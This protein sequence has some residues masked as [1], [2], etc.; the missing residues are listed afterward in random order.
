MSRRAMA[1]QLRAEPDAAAAEVAQ[2]VADHEQ[3]RALAEMQDK[4]RNELLIAKYGSLKKA[5]A[6]EEQKMSKA[7]DKAKTAF[8][9]NPIGYLAQVS[10]CSRVQ[11]AFDLKLSPSTVKRYVEQPGNTPLEVIRRA[12]ILL[13]EMERGGRRTNVVVSFF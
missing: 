9:D 10:K 8:R 6:A 5:K 7:A 1:E 3:A 4:Q 2:R 11:L 12:E 13:M